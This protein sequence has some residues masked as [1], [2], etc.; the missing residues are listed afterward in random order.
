MAMLLAD[1]FSHYTQAFMS[2]MWD[3]VSVPYAVGP[4]PDFLPVT[5]TQSRTAGRFGEGGVVFA[6]PNLVTYVSSSQLPDAQFIQ[7]NYN[8]VSVIHIGLAVL[9][10]GTQVGGVHSGG[11]TA[12]GRLLTLLDGA[13]TQVGIDIM[14]SGQLRAVRSSAVGT[15]IYLA[16]IGTNPGTSVVPTFTELGTS[17]GAIS[18]NAY[19]FLEFK[20]THHP[21]AGIVE[22]KRNT[23]EAFW[24]LSNVNT[25]PSGNNQSA[26][27]LIGG[28]GVPYTASLG[29]LQAHYLRAIVSDVHLL[30]TTANGSD[31]LD[32]VTFI[33]DRHWQVLTP[34]ADGFYTDWTPDP[35]DA[36][37]PDEHAQNVN[38]VPPNEARNNNTSTV[39][40]I[41]S[42]ECDN[43]TGP[44]GA[45][46]IMAYTMYLQ[47]TT[48]GDVGVSGLFRLGGADR[49]GTEFQVPSPNAFEQSFLASKPGGGAIT[50]AD[51]N[52]GEHGYE[53]TS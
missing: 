43:A 40:N 17:T 1:S 39:G 4:E 9:Q 6:A 11:T 3:V 15:G 37:Q 49:N 20:I 10:T 44:G 31:A 22:V 47:K 28:Y 2:K 23:D 7:K 41:D 48:G 51:V 53:L 16:T 26:S 25:A 14:P 5:L 27:M 36:G 32:P 42:F 24:T 19:D 29:E 35:T 12:G 33:G 46:V 50:V 18:S 45:S 13:T 38:T 8:A 52:N 34:T 21:T 30:N